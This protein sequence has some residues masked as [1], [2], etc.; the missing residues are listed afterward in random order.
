MRKNRAPAYLLAPHDAKAAVVV[1]RWV[2]NGGDALLALP[3]DLS[4]GRGRESKEQSCT[5]QSES[6]RTLHGSPT[7]MRLVVEIRCEAGPIP[8]D[9]KK[10]ISFRGMNGALG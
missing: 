1:E 4:I 6:V 2:G 10:V 7:K 5:R 3:D 9:A 8:E